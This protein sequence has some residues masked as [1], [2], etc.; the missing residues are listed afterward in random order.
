MPEKNLFIYI[1]HHVHHE[2]TDKHTPIYIYIQVRL[3]QD[4][5]STWTT[6]G[7]END[8]T[9]ALELNIVD[10]T[11]LTRIEYQVQD[12]HVIGGF[13]ATIYYEGEEYVTTE[14][15]TDGNFEITSTF[16]G[17]LVYYDY[18]ATPWR[19]DLRSPNISPDAKWIW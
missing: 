6:I 16:S 12:L 1:L 15:I 8:W 14:P 18:S 9:Q 11:D 5:G 4:G 7:T 13:I 17:S 19:I 2:Y 3:S 10:V